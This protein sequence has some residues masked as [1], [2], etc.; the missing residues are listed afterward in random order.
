MKYLDSLKF[1]FY[2]IFHPFKGFWDLKHEKRGSM[3]AAFTFLVLLIITY[4]LRRQYTGFIFNEN[5]PKRLNVFIE[6]IS[7]LLPFFLWT[8]ANW[9][10]TTLMDGEGS[11]RDIVIATAYAL[12][13]LI[14]INLPLI[15]FSR[16]INMEEG[17]F[18][19][20]FASVSALWS[21]ALILAGAMVT[22][23]YTA[24]KTVFTSILSVV[25]MGLMIFIGLLV[26]SLLQQMISFVYTIYREIVF[27]L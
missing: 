5:D 12:F 9:C 4:I 16:I 8:T 10:I 1:A 23:Q 15:P 18:Y 20:F 11:Y 13:P 14:L 19:F 17:A 21:G 27:R 24:G 7:V 22:H 6:I 25:G 2:V 3:S 26:F